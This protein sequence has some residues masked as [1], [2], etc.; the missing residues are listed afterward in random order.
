MEEKFT[1]EEQAIYDEH[2][3]SDHAVEFIFISLLIL[4]TAVRQ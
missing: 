4:T 1:P 3:A 2:F